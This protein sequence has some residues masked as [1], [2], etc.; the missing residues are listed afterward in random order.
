MNC[1]HAVGVLSF[2]ILSCG[3]V[4]RVADAVVHVICVDVRRIARPLHSRLLSS[5]RVRRACIARHE[6]D[7]AR[8]VRILIPDLDRVVHHLPKGHVVHGEGA[9]CRADVHGL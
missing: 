1:G 6:A 7:D 3:S 4:E 5:Q 9:A 8:E 2:F